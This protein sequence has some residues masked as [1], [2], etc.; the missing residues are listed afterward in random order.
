MNT[1]NNSCVKCKRLERSQYNSLESRIYTDECVKKLS[2]SQKFRRFCIYKEYYSI[3]YLLW[4]L[5]IPLI[6]GVIF[7][8]WLY[9]YPSTV[10]SADGPSSHDGKPQIFW[11]NLISVIYIIP[12]TVLISFVG[13]FSYVSRR[14]GMGRFVHLNALYLILTMKNRRESDDLTLRTSL[15]TAWMDVLPLQGFLFAGLLVCFWRTR[16]WEKT[17]ILPVPVLLVPLLVGLVGIAFSQAANWL[18]FQVCSISFDCTTWSTSQH[19]GKLQ[20]VHTLLMERFVSVLEGPELHIT[21]KE[22]LHPSPS[23]IFGLHSFHASSTLCSALCLMII[24]TISALLWPVLTYIFHL[25]MSI[26][27]THPTTWALAVISVI[28]Y[29][30]MLVNSS[31]FRLDVVAAA[32]YL[33][34]LLFYNGFVA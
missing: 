12:V 30:V 26:L 8:F 31:D 25:I 29:V 7:Y 20:Y 2:S 28:T 11:I 34:A 32:G 14:D 13:F 5:L 18:L 1:E 10:G 24:H 33:L 22:F 3:L 4:F 23:D 6:G 15:F 16:H 19:C 27:P 9:I 21:M 17:W